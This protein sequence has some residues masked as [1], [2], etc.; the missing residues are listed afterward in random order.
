MSWFGRLNYWFLQWFFLRLAKVVD[1]D[2]D[3]VVGL[4]M[5]VG[6]IPLT[7]WEPNFSYAYVFKNG[8]QLP[9]VNFNKK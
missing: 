9:I 4:T 6:V 3:K 7:G 2:T 1:C 8:L 5:L